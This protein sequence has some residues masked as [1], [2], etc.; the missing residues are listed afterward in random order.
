MK[1]PDAWRPVYPER[2]RKPRCERT[3][4]GFPPTAERSVFAPGGVRRGAARSRAKP[5]SSAADRRE[6]GRPVRKRGALYLMRRSKASGEAL[7]E[8]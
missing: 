6:N 8:A 3:M 4:T 7:G 1:L 5:G 2:S